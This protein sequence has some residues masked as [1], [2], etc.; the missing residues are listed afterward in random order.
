MID[1]TQA[2]I[3][4]ASRVTADRPPIPAEPVLARIRR[5]RAA[6]HA[7]Q[8]VVGLGAAGAVALVGGQLVGADGTGPLGPAGGSWVEGTWPQAV[9]TTDDLSV[10]GA[11][12]GPLHDPP[13]DAEVRLG[14]EVGGSAVTGEPFEAAV[15]L[16][17][18]VDGW[19][20]GRPAT[21]VRLVV[22]SD[23]RVVAVGE[24][25][26]TELP[27]PGA[28]FLGGGPGRGVRITSPATVD[29]VSCAD[30]APLQP[31]LY[32]LYAVQTFT[33]VQVPTSDL[34]GYDGDAASLTF[35]DDEPLVLAGGPAPI[36]VV[37]SPLDVA[38]IPAAVPLVVER[39]LAATRTADGWQVT[40][41][42]DDVEGYAR[43]E[44]ALLAGGYTGGPDLDQR[45][46]AWRADF[47]SDD[48]LVEVDVANETGG[49]ILG[50]YLIVRR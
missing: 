36:E 35:G 24:T 31:G 28:D 4:T 10:C 18:A 17:I 3:D 15:A 43:A 23:D 16:G 50:T 14:I 25:A 2:F 38:G 37:R 6:R 30:G 5:R 27:A 8:G 49:G 29:M 39:L 33:S 46:M 13:G 45:E 19:F 1:L 48:Y 42:F 7:T 9:T 20:F 26:P 34:A 41:E 47:R 32:E 40:V 12:V 21:P 22:V 11:Q 44:A